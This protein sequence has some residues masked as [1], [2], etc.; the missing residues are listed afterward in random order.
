MIVLGRQITRLVLVSLVVAALSGC[1]EA[2]DTGRSAASLAPDDFDVPRTDHLGPLPAWQS[3]AEIELGKTDSFDV[4]GSYSAI[5]GATPAPR[6]GSLRA[7]AEFERTDAVLID[8]DDYTPDFMLELAWAASSAAPLFVITDDLGHTDDVSYFLGQ[9][10]VD[11]DS[12]R[13]FEYYND[14]SWTR[15]YGPI[16]VA[17]ARLAAVLA[18]MR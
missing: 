9:N 8:W 14:S 12:V 13:F 15:D 4:R 7:V 1:G 5:Y 16:P 3:A 18:G 10:G 2:A 17:S 11:T 6:T